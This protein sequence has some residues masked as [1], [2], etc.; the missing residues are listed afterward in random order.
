M[1]V[2]LAYNWWV[3]A[4][5]G[6]A[7]I[8][9]G[10]IALLMP[11]AAVAAIVLVFGAYALVDG[12]LT[13]V[14][15]LRTRDRQ[16][17]WGMMLLEGI[18]SIIAAG[19]AFLAPALAAIALVALVAAWAL[20]TGV[21]EIVAAFRLRKVIRH[22]WLLGLA[23]VASVVFGIALALAPLI[24]AVVL[25]LWIGAYALVF[26]AIQLALA[27]KLRKWAREAGRGP[28]ALQAA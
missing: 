5:R 28:Q 17:R 14:A 27:F 7:G 1:V 12:V 10:I 24:G 25:A 4:L 6:I 9:F 2:V 22:E 11:G 19:I 20:I 13:I 8:L 26:G 3:L 23:G 16:P 18:I 15:A 21:L